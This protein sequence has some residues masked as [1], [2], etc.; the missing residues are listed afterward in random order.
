[1]GL[2][3]QL[4]HEANAKRNAQSVDMDRLRQQTRLLDEKMKLVLT[5]FEQFGQQCEVLQRESKGVFELPG[6]G[7]GFKDLKLTHFRTIQRAKEFDGAEVFHFVQLSYLHKGDYQLHLDL[8]ALNMRKPIEDRIH[9]AALKYS[10]Y[11]RF[12]E[13]GNAAGGRYTVDADVYAVVRC[14]VMTET[15]QIH[16]YLKN[17][18]GFETERFICHVSELSSE[19]LDSVGKYILGLDRQFKRRLSL[20]LSDP[21]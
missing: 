3:D 17:I 11:E 7:T 6:F 8:R 4:T 13:H 1:M 16:F 21:D 10:F 9:S 15:A 12:D 2:L 18:E 14:T 5:Y 20:A 19:L